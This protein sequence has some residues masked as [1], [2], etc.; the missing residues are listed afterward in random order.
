VKAKGGGMGG[1][2]KEKSV[3][4]FKVEDITKRRALQWGSQK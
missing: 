2:G 3:K 1:R 4:K